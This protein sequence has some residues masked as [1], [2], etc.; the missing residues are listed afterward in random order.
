MEDETTDEFPR[1]PSSSP[2]EQDASRDQLRAV[3][4]QATE[5]LDRVLSFLRSSSLPPRMGR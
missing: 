1:A 3:Q 5:R 2:P 4:H